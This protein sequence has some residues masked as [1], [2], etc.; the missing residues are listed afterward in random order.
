[1]LGRLS[2][3]A[4]TFICL[5]FNKKNSPSFSEI[6]LT[7]KIDFHWTLNDKNS[8]HS[9]IGNPTTYSWGPDFREKK[10]TAQEKDFPY[11]WRFSWAFWDTWREQWCVCSLCLILHWSLCGRRGMNE[12]LWQMWRDAVW[13]FSASLFSVLPPE[14]FWKESQRFS[15]NIC[16]TESFF[17]V[18]LFSFSLSLRDSK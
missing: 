7:A 10:E 6:T 4:A 5:F 17:W 2:P 13:S 11:S 9:L 3:P 14:T 8:G 15:K 1:M 18:E 12:Y 16:L